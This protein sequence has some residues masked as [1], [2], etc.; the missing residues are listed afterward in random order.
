MRVPSS[1]M[2][3]LGFRNWLHSVIKTLVLKLFNM[4]L[5]APLYIGFSSSQCEI[6]VLN[7]IFVSKAKYAKD[8]LKRFGLDAIEESYPNSLSLS[9]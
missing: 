3:L 9:L 6:E 4:H 1:A 7:V 5:Y 8:L 2:I